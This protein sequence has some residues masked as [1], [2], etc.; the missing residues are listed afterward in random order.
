MNQFLLICANC[1][2]IFYVTKYFSTRRKYCSQPCSL[3]VNAVKNLGD[4]TTP[5]NIAKRNKEQ[6]FRDRV[7]DGLKKHFEKNPRNQEQWYL[8]LYGPDH[9]PKKLKHCNGWKKLSKSIR[10]KHN[11]QKCGSS[12]KLDVHH[13]IPFAI[14]KDNSLNNLVV[15]CRHCHKGT[16]MNMIKI[17]NM[18]GSWE[19][20][21]ALYKLRFE[22]IGRAFNYE[23]A[24]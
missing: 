7:S 13:I 14:S 12:D 24:Q 2:K 3:A 4:W 15:L 19:C 9:T 20:A 11:C 18:V 17:K 8:D 23:M 6:W 21:R 22:D 1:S 10:A 16:E 5:E